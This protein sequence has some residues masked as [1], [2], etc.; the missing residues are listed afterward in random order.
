[1]ADAPGRRLTT[2]RSTLPLTRGLCGWMRPLSVDRD[3]A[4]AV[5]SS[6]LVSRLIRICRT[7]SGS[8]TISATS[9]LISVVT[10][11]CG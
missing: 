11:T 2:T 5:A 9:G 6:A 8:V 7:S 3:S 1:M 10:R 4:A